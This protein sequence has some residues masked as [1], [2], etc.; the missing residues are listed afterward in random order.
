MAGQRHHVVSRF[1]LRRFSR[2]T[3]RGERVCQLDVRSGA[4][5]QISPTD[6]EVGVGFYSFDSED[7]ERNDVADEVLQVIENGA[8]PMFRRIAHDGSVPVGMDRLNLALYV[9]LARTRTPIAREITRTMVTRLETWR[10]IDHGLDNVVHRA[11]QAGEQIDELVEQRDELKTKLESG[12]LYIEPHKSVLVALALS[13]ATYMAN[14]FFTFEWSIVRTDSTRLVL[15]DAVVSCRDPTP[16]V[17]E[18]GAAPMSSPN[19]ETFVP[20]DPEVGLVLRPTEASFG[21]GSEAEEVL[22]GDDPDRML[23]VLEG[24][25]GGSR[26]V[27]LDNVEADSLNRLS[28]AYA[29]RYIYGR[30]E[31]VASLHASARRDQAAIAALRP[32]PPRSHILEP[33]PGRPGVFR[34]SA[35]IIADDPRAR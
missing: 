24:R 9:A 2:E 28:Y 26:D 29:H 1:L 13:S 3:S 5:K 19:A 27:S 4:N 23:E 8:A 12:E 34:E 7:G 15:P 20:I 33:D 25:Q 11:E 6:A 31:D 16:R 35:T 32:R 18:T 30:Q 22:R 10:M 14:L 17:P 21:L